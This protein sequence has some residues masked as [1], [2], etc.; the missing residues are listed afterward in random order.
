ML[1]YP[2]IW[3]LRTLIYSRDFSGFLSEPGKRTLLE[4]SVLLLEDTCC[5]AL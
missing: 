2:G 1:E 4:K 3:D 5:C